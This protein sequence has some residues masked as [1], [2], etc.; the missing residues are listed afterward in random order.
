VTEQGRALA[1]TAA[2]A[3]VGGLLGYFLFTD[4]GRALR[5]DF[6]PA[7]DDLVRELN[8][9]R[10]TVV[11]AVAMAGEGWKLLTD[12]TAENVVEPGR[13]THPRQTSPF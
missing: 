13:Y 4:R 8:N 2:G 12:F 9:F 7:L 10:G 6:E 1:A 11:K 3:I 5:R